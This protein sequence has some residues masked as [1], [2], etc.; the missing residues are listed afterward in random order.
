MSF[1][2]SFLCLSLLSC[3]SASADDVLSHFYTP[4]VK[5]S[6]MP[7][8][9]G[10]LLAPSVHTI[11]TGHADF[12]PYLFF[13]AYTGSYNQNWQSKSSPNFYSVQLQVPGWVGLTSFMD[14]SIAP[15]IMYQFTRGARDF[16]FGDIP[17]TIS[18]QLLNEKPGT[19]WPA[20]KLGLQATIPSAKYDNLDP[21][22]LGTDAAGTGTWFPNATLAMGRLFL[23]PNDHFLSPRLVFNYAVPNATRVKNLNAYGGTAGTRGTVYPGNVCWGDLGLEYNLTQN[24]ALAFDLFYVH[25]NKNRFSGFAGMIAPGVPAVMTR[26]SSEQLSLAPAIEY[27][28][29]ANI[30]LIGGVW[31]TVTGRNS[32]RFV[33]TVLAFNAYI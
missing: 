24:W 21:S 27:N 14:L 10:P 31:F 13:W 5:D 18:F 7:W 33:T 9:T 19:W 20:I 1:K 2:K 26:P 29:S 15:K 30:G 11:P 3:W 4:T 32:S 23:L 6:E 17:V 28:W 25:S 8:F 12:E 22:K 16:Q